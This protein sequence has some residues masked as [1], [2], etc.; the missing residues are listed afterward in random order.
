MSR[1]SERF[2]R[3]GPPVQK[4]FV[5]GSGVTA[6]HVQ[7]FLFG[8]TRRG[9]TIELNDDRCCRTFHHLWQEVARNITNY[10]SFPRLIG[11][12]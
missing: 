1:F 11:G 7:A 9:L 8:E 3:F 10:K 4:D 6:S 2:E 5:A 12:E